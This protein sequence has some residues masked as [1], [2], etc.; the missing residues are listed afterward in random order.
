MT[1]NA[2]NNKYFEWLSDRVS[3]ERYS[4]HLSYTKL[5]VRLHD[6]DFRYSIPKD[7]NRAEDGMD[8]RWRFANECDISYCDVE[9]AV[10][11]PCSVLEMMVALSIR[12]E[13]TIMDDPSI[14]DRT[15]QWFWGMV[16]NLGLGSMT[17]SRFDSEYVDDILDRF[18]DRDY[19]PNGKGGLFTLR[20]CDCD[21]RDMEIFHQL[22]YFLGDIV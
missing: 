5:L 22:C 11:R 16:T 19:E 12:C 9:D 8:L 18:L 14:G 3:S 10:D 15:R 2:I 20:H 6:T 13:E 4:E 21:A 1:R 17:D 7:E